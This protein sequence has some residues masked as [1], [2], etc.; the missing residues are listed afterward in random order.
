M[1]GLPVVTM[2][3][4]L[5]AD[6]E[7][8]FTASGAAV[9]NFSVACNDRRF[10][11]NSNSFVDGDATF[12]RCS[13]WRQD[14]ENLAQTGRRG[15]RVIVTGELKQRSWD[16]KDGQKRTVLELAATEVGISL[17]FAIA[18]V[19]KSTSGGN[20]SRSGASSQGGRSQPAG[21]RST[22]HEDPWGPQGSDSPPF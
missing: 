21:T 13:I 12:L 4:T 16:D 18:E 3:G 11:K 15:H 17:K 10:D 6:P 5:V 7:L 1:S 22:Q 9:A 20:Q 14:A 8:T 2:I 19:T